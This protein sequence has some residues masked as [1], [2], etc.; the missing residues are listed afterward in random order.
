MAVQVDEVTKGIK[1][2]SLN[3]KKSGI[4]TNSVH[5]A[6]GS[7]PTSVPNW[8]NLTQQNLT[9]AGGQLAGSFHLRTV[10]NGILAQV[11]S[12][13]KTSCEVT[14]EAFSKRIDEVKEAKNK[15]EKQK[16]ETIVKIQEVENTIRSLEQAV[17]AK[18]GP[19]ATCQAKIHQRRLRPGAEYCHDEVDDQLAK[20]QRNLLELINKLEAGLGQAKQCYG[21]LQKTLLEL[22][23][24]IAKKDNSVYIDQVK[25]GT[26]RRSINIHCY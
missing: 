1:V 23:D 18:Q 21:Q 9:K 12:N 11:A 17:M 14:D 24:E 4:K 16:S 20:E 19:L 7:H 3:A 10:V 8:I 15:L 22:E 26:I 6:R 2:T 25:C 5:Q 13:L